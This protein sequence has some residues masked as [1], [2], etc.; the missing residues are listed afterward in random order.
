M[1]GEPLIHKQFYEITEYAKENLKDKTF[2]LGTNAVLLKENEHLINFIKNNYDEICIGCDLEHKNL[3]ILKDIVPKLCE[4]KKNIIVINSI[5]EYSSKELLEELKMLKKK[6][7]NNIIL[8][9]N[10][11][12]HTCKDEPINNLGLGLCKQNNKK[13]LL[14]QENGDTYRCFNCCVPDDK[15][16]NIFDSNFYEKINEERTKHYKF[17][18]WCK[19]YEP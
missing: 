16:M 7:Y 14:I 18:A 10:H 5:I 2:V 9:T 15:E 13:Y 19:N 12:Y 1:V 8:V 11:V 6:Y 3:N 4:N 17:C